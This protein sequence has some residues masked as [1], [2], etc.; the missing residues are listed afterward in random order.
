M[1]TGYL[2]DAYAA[3]NLHIAD[4]NRVKTFGKDANADYASKLKATVAMII[5]HTILN[6]VICWHLVWRFWF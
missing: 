6:N 4:K 1:R 5:L 3:F 2:L